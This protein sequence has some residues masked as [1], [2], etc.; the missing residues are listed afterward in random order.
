VVGRDGHPAP[1]LADE[2]AA[3]GAMR[4]GLSW[5]FARPPVR[6]LD[7]EMDVGGVMREIVL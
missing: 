4:A 6:D 5:H 1:F 7:Y 2:L 3:R